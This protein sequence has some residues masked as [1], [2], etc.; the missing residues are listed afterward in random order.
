M[1]KKASRKEPD[2]SLTE[3]VFKSHMALSRKLYE[4][5]IEEL[6]DNQIGEKLL[7]RISSD[8]EAVMSL[9]RKLF[10]EDGGTSTVRDLQ[11]RL[12]N[13]V[14]L[15]YEIKLGQS[16]PPEDLTAEDSEALRAEARQLKK[17]KKNI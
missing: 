1:R 2:G 17:R 11:K 5:A 4:G 15:Q 12:P 14:W 9:R 8:F 7:A 10:E 3:A 6:R 13:N 16:M